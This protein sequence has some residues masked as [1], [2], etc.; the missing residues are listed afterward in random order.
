MFH[1]LKENLSVTRFLI[2]ASLCL[3][4]VALL[5]DHKAVHWVTPSAVFAQEKSNTYYAAQFRGAD[6]FT[7][8]A[9]AQ[10]S[11]TTNPS[12]N[13]N[14]IIVID[15]I[16]QGWPAGTSINPCAN[17]IWLDYTS[18][19]TL[20][21]AMGNSSFLHLQNNV[22]N[23]LITGNDDGGLSL[24]NITI[25]GSVTP[26]SGSIGTVGTVFRPFA[27]VVVGSGQHNTTTISTGTLTSDWSTTLPDGNSATVVS[28]TFTTT[29]AATDNVT[30][31][32][33]TPSGHCVLQPRNAAAA[34]GIASVFVS[35]K[36][37]NQI[38]VTHTATAGWIFDVVCSPI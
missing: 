35:A 15:S 2:L 37:T 28:A 5:P 18:P 19:G 17:C 25:S 7:K 30:V 13:M 4:S 16:L 8:I 12:F 24:G 34:A 32:G 14:C 22:V 33:M 6:K 31:Q 3:V 36:A 23:D 21:M 9:N 26:T 29:A 11:C 10:N 27:G 1:W 20:T 38:T